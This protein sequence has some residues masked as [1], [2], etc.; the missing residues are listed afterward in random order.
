MLVAL[1]RELIKAEFRA[2]QLDGHSRTKAAR[3]SMLVGA[4]RPRDAAPLQA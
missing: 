3:A 1:R 4:N 2:Q